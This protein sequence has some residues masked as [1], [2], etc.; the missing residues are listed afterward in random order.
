MNRHP[1]LL[2]RDV[3]D[4]AD[5]LVDAARRSGPSDAARG[6]LVAV[7]GGAAA[8]S[9][10]AAASAAALSATGSPHATA[11]IGGSVAGAGMGKAVAAVTAVSLAKWAGAGMLVGFGV[12]GAA[13]RAGVLARSNGGPGAALAPESSPREEQ[14]AGGPR[15][16]QRAK[17]GAGP[18]G[19]AA[20]REPGEN[21]ITAPPP[22][23]EPAPVGAIVADPIATTVSASRVVPAQVHTD[24]VP[25]ERATIPPSSAPSSQLAAEVSLLD[26]ARAALR[27]GDAPAALRG[28]DGYRTQFPNGALANEASV[29]RV[30]TLLATGRR[31]EAA[32]EA[33]R[34]LARNPPGPFADR[35]RALMALH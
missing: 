29:V 7:L 12:L 28:L 5:R 2:E 25:H 19:A 9:T 35:V 32:G 22:R 11:G 30:E 33:A 26:A 16:P 1:N 14:T 23:K 15:I 3:G 24:G 17:D 27:G 8:A 20:P 18:A 34:F 31:D 4:I 10:T 13:D 21:A 6:R